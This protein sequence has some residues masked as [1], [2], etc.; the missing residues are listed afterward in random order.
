MVQFKL[1]LFSSASDMNERYILTKIKKKYAHF[2]LNICE[3]NDGLVKRLFAIWRFFRFSF[4]VPEY[5]T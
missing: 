5:V 3:I 4:V 1:F 2:I